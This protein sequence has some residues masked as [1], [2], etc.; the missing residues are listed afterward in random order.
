MSTSTSLRD[1]GLT[2][3]E[4]DIYKA[5]L[6]IGASPASSIAKETGIKRTTAYSLLQ[7]LK[8]KGFVGGYFRAD[9][10]LFYAERPER[11]VS[12]Y[13]KRL[14]AFTD[15]IPFLVQA[16]RR[17]EGQE[18]IH[19]ITTV[20]ELKDFYR[21]ILDEYRN[22]SYSIIGNSQTWEGL[23]SDFFQQFRRDRAYQKIKTRLLLDSQSEIINP[24]DP[25]LLRCWK[26]VPSRYSFGGVIDIFDDKILL[27]STELRSLAVVI[28]NPAMVGIFKTMF[29]IIWDICPEKTPHGCLTKAAL[30]RKT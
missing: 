2:D 14:R 19:P 4:S 3:P 24:K 26:Y 5:L 7:N 22:K 17:Q 13:E 10:Q 18:G 11:V 9:R 30:R 6:K 25:V 20:A 29:D 1:M 27:I 16:E 15:I 12:R 28:A 23:D 21:D 8:E